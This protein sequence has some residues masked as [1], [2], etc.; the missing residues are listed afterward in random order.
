MPLYRN[1][2]SQEEIDYEYDL[3][4]RSESFPA[5]ADTWIKAS[6]E[7]R[8][9]LQCEL[10]VPFGPTLDETIDI[11]PAKEQGAPVFVFIHGGYWRALSSKEFS[12][13]ARDIQAAGYTVVISNYSLCPK[14]SISEITRQSRA[15]ISYIAKH[16]AKYNGDTERICVAGHSAGGHQ[17]AMMLCTDWEGEYGLDNNI[18]KTCIAMS[19]VYDLEPLR[20]SYLQPVLQLDHELIKQQSPIYNLKQSNCSVL[21]TLGEHE[22]DEFH[23]QAD[24]YL[25]AWQALGNKATLQ[26]QQGRDHFTLLDDMALLLDKATKL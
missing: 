15:A 14:V 6:E 10:D 21:V 20:Y 11:F 3:G 9:E 19:G 8:A 25:Q 4:A 5:I 2:N 26:A 16:A 12:F 17:A 24:A 1:F 18:I 22:P 7:T 13:I 23:R